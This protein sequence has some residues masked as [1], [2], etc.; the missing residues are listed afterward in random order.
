MY[1]SV[2]VEIP[3]R[4]TASR[5][6]CVRVSP[7]EFL[8]NP[9]KSESVWSG[10]RWTGMALNSVGTVPFQG[11]VPYSAWFPLA[12]SWGCEVAG[13]AARNAWHPGLQHPLATW[14][15][16]GAAA[17]S[18]APAGRVADQKCWLGSEQ[19]VCAL[20]CPRFRAVSLLYPCAVLFKGREVYSPEEG[21]AKYDHC[22][23]AAVSWLKT[24]FFW[25]WE[26][27]KSYPTHLL[28]KIVNIMIITSITPM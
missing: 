20:Y 21:V 3:S 16:L 27:G 10:R 17:S 1:K 11:H 18:G 15:S 12:P 4:E 14:G 2:E 28:T 6:T 9:V 7:P 23:I 26:E 8:G 19:R 22:R 5:S 13:P 25:V 24:K